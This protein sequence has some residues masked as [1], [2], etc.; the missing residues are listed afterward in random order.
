M[1]PC[2]VHTIRRHELLYLFSWANVQGVYGDYQNS[3]GYAPYLPYSS[4]SSHVGYDSQLYAPQHYQYPTSYF[5]PSATTDGPYSFHGANSSHGDVSTASVV[6][7]QLQISMGT[8]KGNQSAFGN[9]F[10]NQSNVPKPVRTNYQKPLTRS[11]DL[12]GW[13]GL[14]SGIPSSLSQGQFCNKVL[15]FH[16]CSLIIAYCSLQQVH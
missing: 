10:G 12:Y 13:G 7:D 8:G 4:S 6:A 1:I 14:A 2:E 11:N 15:Y 5:Q 16:S 3:Y 9:A